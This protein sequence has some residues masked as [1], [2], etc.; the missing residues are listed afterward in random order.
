MESHKKGDLTESI[1]ITELKRRQIPVSVPFGDNERYDLTVEAPT[2]DFYSIQVK[3][4]R[5][6]DG[7]V[8]FNGM[9]QHTNSSGNVYKSYHDDVDYFLVYCY[10][11]ETLYLIAEQEFDT[12]MELRV[13]TPEQVHRTINWAEEYEFDTRWPPED[14]NGTENGDPAVERAIDALRESQTEVFRRVSDDDQKNVKVLV[15]NEPYQLRIENGWVVDGRIRFDG[16]SEDID[17]YLVYCDELDTLYV[18]DDAEFER[19]ISLRIEEPEQWNSSINW[20]PD[21][22]FEKNWPPK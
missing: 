10:E 6:R 16:S 17:R 9:S 3:T 11:L 12:R 2:G 15:K 13:E 18:I 8:R 1:V 21:Y 5:Y 19:A 14:D 22:E 4:G 7:L 20:A